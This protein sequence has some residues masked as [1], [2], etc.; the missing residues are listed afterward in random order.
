MRQIKFRAWDESKLRYVTQ[1]RKVCIAL[2]GTIFYHN[3]DASCIDSLI[4][5]RNDLKIEQFTGLKDKNGKEI[6]EDDIFQLLIGIS[7]KR[8]IQVNGSISSALH[9]A[10][11]QHGCFG[12]VPIHPDKVHP[13]D[14]EWRPFFD[15]E[16]GCDWTE[17][18]EIIGNIHQ[19]PELL[20][21]ATKKP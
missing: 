14:R 10:K 4:F 9:R 20:K 18:I 15:H 16:D 5:V 6:Y 21:E 11:F 12:F 13:D 17:D 3:L 8:F 2:D 1:T 19:H 7:K